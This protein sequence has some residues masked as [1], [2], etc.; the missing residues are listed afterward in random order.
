MHL[1]DGLQCHG[2]RSCGVKDPASQKAQI[3]VILYLGLNEN[4]FS[5]LCIVFYTIIELYL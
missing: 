3:V 5:S 4:W 1:C 2:D